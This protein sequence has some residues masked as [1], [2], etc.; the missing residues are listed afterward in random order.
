MAYDE[1]LADRIRALFK[2]RN[3]PIREMNM[4]GGYCVMLDEKMC[5]GIVKEHLMA[6]VGPANYEKAL[7]INGAKPMGFT[8]RP[9]KGYVFVAPE[10]IDTD[11]DLDLWI[12]LSVAYNPEAKSS[13]KKK[14]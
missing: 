13:K 4:M 3:L 9:M 6:R 11:K 12:G 8:G 2:Q 14:K 1:Y 10:A 7:Q 5:V